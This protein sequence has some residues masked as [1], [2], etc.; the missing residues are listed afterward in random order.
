MPSRNRDDSVQLLRL[1]VVKL[2][3]F[4]RT[5]S[6]IPLGLLPPIET[7][8]IEYLLH[9]WF[10]GDDPPQVFSGDVGKYFPERILPAFIQRTGSGRFQEYVHRLVFRYT[11]LA[12]YEFLPRVRP[13]VRWL[14][15]RRELR[16]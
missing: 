8:C 6:L 1:T 12:C 13:G 9:D 14:R 2:P 15:G 3:Y 5:V 4:P 11:R 16:P 7:D 10:F